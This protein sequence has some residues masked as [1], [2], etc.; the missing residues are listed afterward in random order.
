[1]TDRPFGPKKPRNTLIALARLL[2]G[3]RAAMAL[4]DATPRGFLN[5]FIPL[6]AL[7]VVAAVAT[8]AKGDVP[9]A[10]TDLLAAVCVLALPPVISHAL[11]RRWQREDRWLRFAVMF[12]WTQFGLS[13]LFVAVLAMLGVLLGTSETEPATN[14]IVVA[15][16]LLCLAVLCYGLWLH[17]FI[18]RHGLNLT[19]GQA[20]FVVFATYAG[21]L[22]L[23]LGHSL[24]S[25]DRG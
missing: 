12:N 25:L 5:S 8:L 1:M 22:V 14:G 20:A 7:P 21:T 24:L 23:V 15:V 9:R 3:D 2:R 16:V 11:A 17:W 13:A 18:A 4:F 10:L 6:A 19:R